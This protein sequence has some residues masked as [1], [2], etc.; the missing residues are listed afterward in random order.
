MLDFHVGNVLEQHTHTVP[1]TPSWLHSPLPFPSRKI[2][3]TFKEWHECTTVCRLVSSIPP[4]TAFVSLPLCPT[5]EPMYVSDFN[6]VFFHGL[7]FVMKFNSE[8][9]VSIHFN[10]RN[11]AW[12]GPNI[13]V[14][15]SRG[16]WLIVEWMM[17]CSPNR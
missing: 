6:T 8:I 1:S 13:V 9:L 12:P 3:K 10:L 2:I 5:D 14:F 16:I 15:R 17:K 11:S 7:H 4:A